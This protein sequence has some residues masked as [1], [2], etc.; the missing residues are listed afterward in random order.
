[1]LVNHNS[2]YKLRALTGFSLVEVI[3]AMSIIAIGLSTMA[4]SIFALN[5][6]NRMAQENKRAVA[7]AQKVVERIQAEPWSR[8]GKNPASWHRRENP[9][10]GL[11]YVDELLAITDDEFMHRPLV[12]APNGPSL[13]TYLQYGNAN[14]AHRTNVEAE[15][16]PTDISIQDFKRDKYGLPYVKFSQRA[17]FNGVDTDA[18]SPTGTLPSEIADY[19]DT[20]SRYNWLQFLGILDQHSGLDDLKVYVEFYHMDSMVGVLNRT[21]F[22]DALAETKNQLAQSHALLDLEEL[23]DLDAESV[24]I[25]VI[26]TWERHNGGDGRHVLSLARR[27]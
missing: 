25:R 5:K 24:V 11:Q 23:D 19:Y 10:A 2:F 12:D 17:E 26:V 9:T 14:L 15:A 7:V 20:S 4:S 6:S 27:Q 18:E 16:R 21:D 1:M 13:Y 8:L 3:I 22:E